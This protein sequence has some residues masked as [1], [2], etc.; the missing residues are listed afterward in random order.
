MV[1]GTRLDPELK[2]ASILVQVRALRHQ[3]DALV[4]NWYV[5]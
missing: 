5:N 3:L 1:Y 2:R 4:L